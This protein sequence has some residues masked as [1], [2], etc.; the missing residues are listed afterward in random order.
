MLDIFGSFPVG[1]RRRPTFTPEER[2]AV[3]RKDQGK[4]YL[5][6]ARLNSNSFQV[7]H[8]TPTDRGG[9]HR[10]GNWGAACGGCNARKGNRTVAEYRRW[11]RQQQAARRPKAP[12]KPRA[13]PP[14]QARSTRG[15]AEADFYRFFGG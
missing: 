13:A 5:C 6:G 11:L 4:C 3:Y 10:L 1:P 8:K 12:P 7:D 9:A 2:R 14:R 15:S